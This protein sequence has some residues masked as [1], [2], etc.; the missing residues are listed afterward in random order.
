MIE[1]MRSWVLGWKPEALN[2][3][4]PKHK[5]MQKRTF[6]RLV[7]EHDTFLSQGLGGFM[8][9]LNRYKLD[10]ALVEDYLPW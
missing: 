2:G 3:H 10:T 6:D 1:R 7:W 9:Y 5:G 4:G 8:A